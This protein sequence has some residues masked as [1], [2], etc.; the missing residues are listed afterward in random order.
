M[1]LALN[2]LILNV[3]PSNFHMCALPSKYSQTWKVFVCKQP[4]PNQKVCDL[5]GNSNMKAPQLT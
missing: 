3:L 1:S 5:E 4:T 2:E